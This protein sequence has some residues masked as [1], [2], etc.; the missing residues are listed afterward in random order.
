MTALP[1]WGKHNQH[2]LNSITAS[3]GHGG[4]A[5]RGLPS[6]VP[7]AAHEPAARALRR[8]S[9]RPVPTAGSGAARRRCGRGAGI[10]VGAEVREQPGSWFPLVR[11]RVVL[12]A[13]REKGLG[14]L[15]HEPQL[16]PARS[17]SSRMSSATVSLRSP[18]LLLGEHEVDGEDPQASAG[19]RDWHSCDFPPA[20]VRGTFRVPWVMCQLS[21]W[22][23]CLLY[24]N[25]KSR[26][27]VRE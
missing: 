4:T 23:F 19:T 16:C 12:P 6:P 8:R 26:T 9:P 5:E 3:P 15:L 22:S 18:F 2:Y 24:L 14:K 7:A 17:L 27:K 1:K 21:C 20:L 25:T 10:R 11:R 13:G